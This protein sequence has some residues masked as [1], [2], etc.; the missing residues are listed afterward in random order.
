MVSC[1]LPGLRT[2]SA[3]L[4]RPLNTSGVRYYVN[5]KEGKK[6]YFAGEADWRE[7]LPETQLTWL[8][9]RFEKWMGKQSREL[10][11]L[12]IDICN[13]G[14]RFGM[15]IPRPELALRPGFVKGSWEWHMHMYGAALYWHLAITPGEPVHEIDIDR[16]RG[17]SLLELA[18]MRGG[19]SRYL[20]EVAGTSEYV[21]TDESQ[22]NIEFCRELHPPFTSLRFERAEN[23]G[24]AEQYEADSFDFVLCV[25][26]AS[27]FKNKTCFMKGVQHV[28]RP[29]G[30]VLLCDAFTIPS[31]R[32]TL[33]C[34]KSAGLTQEVCVDIGKWVRATGLS[35]VDIAESNSGFGVAPAVYMRIIGRKL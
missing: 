14:G 10:Y 19:G 25:E 28:L 2:C 27:D 18:C 17:K 13:S 29:G 21:A 7:W 32:E 23:T 30:C 34:M 26:A 16:L 15:P 6:G 24:L 9:Y 5:R 12:S 8:L 4:S 3:L 35:P 22:E 20:A 11:P 1:R 31:L 33:D